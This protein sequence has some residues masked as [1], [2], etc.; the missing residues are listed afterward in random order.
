VY[1]LAI[2]LKDFTNNYY[3]AGPPEYL[4]KILEAGAGAVIQLCSSSEPRPEPKKY[5]KLQNTENS[6]PPHKVSVQQHM[7]NTINP[8]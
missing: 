8:T 4:I 5:F 6:S 2:Y 3:D 1:L 7:Q